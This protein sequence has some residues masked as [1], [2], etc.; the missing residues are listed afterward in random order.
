MRTKIG[1][2]HMPRLTMVNTLSKGFMYKKGMVITSVSKDSNGVTTV[3]VTTEAQVRA[4]NK[5]LRNRKRNK[6]QK[7]A[8]KIN[9]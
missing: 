9:W 3:S 1:G 4:K 7:V 2:V 6:L 8:R 5:R